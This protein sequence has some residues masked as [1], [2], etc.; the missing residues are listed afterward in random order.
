[1]AVPV[2]GFA[3]GFAMSIVETAVMSTAAIVIVV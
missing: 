1:M 2:A 3:A